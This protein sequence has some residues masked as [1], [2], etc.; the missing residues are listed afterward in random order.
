MPWNGRVPGQPAIPTHSRSF[1]ASTPLAAKPSSQPI[2]T[3]YHPHLPF[4]VHIY[5]QLWLIFPG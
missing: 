3:S 1:K 2:S 4:P 5:S